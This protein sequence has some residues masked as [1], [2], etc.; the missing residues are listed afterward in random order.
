MENITIL[1]LTPDIFKFG[2]EDQRQIYMLLY[3]MLSQP[4]LCKVQIS[5]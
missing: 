4:W 3:S 5:L 2:I 1:Q